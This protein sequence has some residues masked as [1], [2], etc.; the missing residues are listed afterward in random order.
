[1]ANQE[2]KRTLIEAFDSSLSPSPVAKALRSSIIPPESPTST[3]EMEDKENQ[4][5]I[6][7]LRAEDPMAQ[8]SNDGE[9]SRREQLQS[10][11]QG[12]LVNRSMPD[13]PEQL[14]ASGEQRGKVLSYPADKALMKP[15]NRFHLEQ[16]AESSSTTVAPLHSESGIVIY[17]DQSA[18]MSDAPTHVGSSLAQIDLGLRHLSLSEAARHLEGRPLKYVGQNRA[19]VSIEP[20]SDWTR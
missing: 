14:Y 19:S 20:K 18:T 3:V 12:P 5:P 9:S 17:Q 10:A 13:A 8:E 4:P 7:D 16:A 1:M 15:A 2:K 6:A 11:V